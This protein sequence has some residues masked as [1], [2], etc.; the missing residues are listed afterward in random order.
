MKAGYKIYRPGATVEE[1]NSGGWFAWAWNWTGGKEEKPRDSKSGTKV[2][3][4][5]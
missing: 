3:F 5:G 2:Y 4:C 1:D